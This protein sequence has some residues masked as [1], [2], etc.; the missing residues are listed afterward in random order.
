MKYGEWY[1]RIDKDGDGTPELRYICT[2]GE[3]REIAR[4]EPANRI[5]FALFSCDPISH[6]IVGDSLADYTEEDSAHQDQHDAGD[7]RQRAESIN[8]KTVINELM[9]TVEDALNDDLGAVI[10]TR[11]DPG[12]SVMFTHTPFLASRRCRWWRC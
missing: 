10:R 3:E 12:N 6:T 7:S 4:D 9:V 11:G 1:I 5:K 8:R 2:F